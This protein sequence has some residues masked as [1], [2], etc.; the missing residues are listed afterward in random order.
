[1]PSVAAVTEGDERSESGE[2][3]LTEVL[4]ETLRKCLRVKTEG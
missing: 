3:V 2:G 4:R 1:M